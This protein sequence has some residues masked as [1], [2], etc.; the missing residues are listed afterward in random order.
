MNSSRITS[1]SLTA[2]AVAIFSC[3]AA[4]WLLFSAAIG[5]EENNWQI[6]LAILRLEVNRVDA[7]PI[8]GVGEASLQENRTRL[9]IANKPNK[10]E[11]YLAQLG[12]QPSDRLGATTVFKKDKPQA[13]T[14]NASCGLYSRFYA[15]CDLSQPIAKQ[16]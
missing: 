10:L 12:W 7:V 5:Q 4:Y 3:A 1:F 14:L 8:E 15:I 16:P 6:H 2:I 11:R 13:Q 9:L